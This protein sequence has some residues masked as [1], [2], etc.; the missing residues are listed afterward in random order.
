M[1]YRGW[2]PGTGARLEPVRV[3]PEPFVDL[4]EEHHRR[5]AARDDPAEPFRQCSMAA[6][7]VFLRGDASVSDQET[8]HACRR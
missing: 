1:L 8:D 4:V 7:R 2:L 3:E 5:R 6:Q